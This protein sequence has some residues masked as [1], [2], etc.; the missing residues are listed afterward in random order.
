PPDT[1]SVYG[2][3]LL[4]IVGQ[5]KAKPKADATPMQRQPGFACNPLPGVSVRYNHEKMKIIPS[6][7]ATHT[8]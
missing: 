1:N 3:I 6:C 5:G 4:Y 7:Q 8:T 2:L